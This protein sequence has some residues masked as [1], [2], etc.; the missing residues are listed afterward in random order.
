MEVRFADPSLEALETDARARPRF[1]IG[2]LRSYRRRI[3]QLRAAQDERDLYA[4][5]GFHFERYKAK[6]DH[7]SIRL[8]DQYRLIIRFEGSPSRKAVV[9]VA[10]TDYH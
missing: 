5:G 8:N 1:P 6:E 10:V 9:V 3:W 2:V 4:V 7:Y